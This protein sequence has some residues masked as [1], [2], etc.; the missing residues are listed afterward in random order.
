VGNPVSDPDPIPLLFTKI[1]KLR[2][3]GKGIQITLYKDIWYRTFWKGAEFW[4]RI[5]SEKDLDI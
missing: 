5:A 1:K 2:K 3:L 4:G